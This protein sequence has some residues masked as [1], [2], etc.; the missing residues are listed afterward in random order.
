LEENTGR[1]WETV[2]KLTRQKTNRADAFFA[3]VI[4]VVNKKPNKFTRMMNYLL[5]IL[6]PVRRA[7]HKNQ[8]ETA[9]KLVV[10]MLCTEQNKTYGKQALFSS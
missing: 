3:Y 8:S 10:V 5:R 1:E 6:S 2:D 7:P 9:K 4:W